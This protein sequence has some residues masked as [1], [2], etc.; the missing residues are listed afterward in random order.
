LALTAIR[1]RGGALL[2]D[3]PD[4]DVTEAT[5]AGSDGTATELGTGRAMA[6]R[7]VVAE[8]GLFGDAEGLLLRNDGSIAV[9]API[10]AKPM[11]AP[12]A[13]DFAAATTR[14]VLAALLTIIEEPT[15]ADAEAV[16]AAALVAT[17][18]PAAAV[19]NAAQIACQF[20]SIAPAAGRAD[21]PTKSSS[22]S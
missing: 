11:A 22:R 10:T 12:T 7:A 18:L 8:E 6:R 1:S 17:K 19:P 21:L 20:A 3:G 9:L 13:S 14:P 4:E 16:L 15:L 5:E 2:G